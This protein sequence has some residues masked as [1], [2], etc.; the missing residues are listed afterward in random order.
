MSPT[1]SRLIDLQPSDDLGGGG[2][3]SPCV[4]V[5]WEESGGCCRVTHFLLNI[6]HI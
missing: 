4:D 2:G 1:L 3:L 5:W 6:D